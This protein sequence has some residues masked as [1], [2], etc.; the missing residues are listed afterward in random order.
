MFTDPA[1]SQTDAM[2]YLLTGKSAS[3]LHGEEGAEVASAAQSVGSVLGNRLAK[4][5][6][7]KVGFID[8]VGVEQNNDLG[9]SAFTVGKYLSPRLFVSYGVGPVRARQRHYR[10]LRVLRALVAGGERHA[11]GRSTPACATASKSERAPRYVSLLGRTS[12]ATASAYTTSTLSPFL[13]L[14]D[15]RR[16]LRHFRTGSVREVP[17]GRVK[18]TV[19]A[20]VS[21][22]SMTTVPCMAVPTPA[23]G[24]VARLR[25]G[26][27]RRA[28]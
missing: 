2:S 13:S 24:L 9:G 10:A 12:T 20:L 16:G 14:R 26:G 3:D 22:F 11:R 1:M 6:G 15:E 23:P 18:V 8:E 25:L 19:F 5:L 28:G 4:K 7:G 21:T 27:R 17:S